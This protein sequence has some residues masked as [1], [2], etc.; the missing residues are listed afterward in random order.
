MQPD[1]DR[2]SRQVGPTSLL[3]T[4]NTVQ[5][6]LSCPRSP[7]SSAFAGFYL[8]SDYATVELV[9]CEYMRRGGI[10]CELQG[11][12]PTR[13]ETLDCLDEERQIVKTR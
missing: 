7:G 1:S 3:L 11:T 6:P 9:S 2:D 5:H 13:F 10:I 12:G 4:F 8:A